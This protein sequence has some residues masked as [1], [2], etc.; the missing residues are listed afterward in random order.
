M[1][2]FV[3]NH[4]GSEET[5]L[6]YIDRRIADLRFEIEQGDQTISRVQREQAAHCNRVRALLADREALIAAGRT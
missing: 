6:Q 4:D 5:T 3:M 2:L 1:S